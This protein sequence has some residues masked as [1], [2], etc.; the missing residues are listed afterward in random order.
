MSAPDRLGDRTEP[1]CVGEIPQAV[2]RVPD[3]AQERD[4]RGAAQMKNRRAS[5]MRS[6]GPPW[7]QEMTECQEPQPRT[8]AN[9]K[10]QSHS[11]IEPTGGS[12]FAPCPNGQKYREPEPRTQ[13]GQL[14]SSSHS[15]GSPRSKGALLFPPATGAHLPSDIWEMKRGERS[16]HPAGKPKQRRVRNTEPRARNPSMLGDQPSACSLSSQTCPRQIMSQIDER[17]PRKITAPERQRAFKKPHLRG[18]ELD[19]LLRSKALSTQAR[20]KHFSS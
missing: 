17:T 14:A 12:V 10:P 15:A 16:I 13:A 20:I 1:Q 19:T 4:D 9:R 8:G 18:C 2:P 5:V 3:I 7:K 6:W 11:R